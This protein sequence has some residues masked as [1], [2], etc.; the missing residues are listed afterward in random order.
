MDEILINYS[1]SQDV[2]AAHLDIF[3]E[4]K[5]TCDRWVIETER[6]K[7]L[8]DNLIHM[9]S[10]FTG[11]KTNFFWKFI[12]GDFYIFFPFQSHS[13]YLTQFFNVIIRVCYNIDSCR[14]H[15]FSHIKKPDNL[16]VAFRRK[17]LLYFWMNMVWTPRYL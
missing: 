13:K 2:C 12:M 16:D 11:T 10:F 9:L 7:K 6:R 4:N 15:I 8:Q 17:N 5:H 14:H 1:L 3:H